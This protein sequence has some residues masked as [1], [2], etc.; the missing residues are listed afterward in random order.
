MRMG[1]LKRTRRL[2]KGV[3]ASAQ[4][5]GETGLH[6][7]AY[8]GHAK[9]VKLLLKSKAPV[10]VKDRRFD[11]TPLGWALYGWCEPAPD[12]D[13]DGYYEVVKQLVSAGA[14]VKEEWLDESKRGMPIARK[15]RKDR[16]M[17]AAL[18]ISPRFKD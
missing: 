18:K 16:W 2:E 15:V 3:D 9:I 5:H 6:W 13:K 17:K 14:A 12:A 10:N 4:P 11:G 8:G 1:V 7:A